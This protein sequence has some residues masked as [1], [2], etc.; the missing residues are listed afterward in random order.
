MKREVRPSVSIVKCQTYEEEEVFRSLRQSVDLLG[1]IRSFVKQGDHVLLKPNLL[2]GKEP[3]KAV[4]THPS[5]VK[6]AIHLVHE[7][8]GIPFIGDSP[9]FGSAGR[10]AEKSGIKTIA[11]EA[12]CPVVEFNNP[13]PWPKGGMLFRQFEV[14]Q[15]VLDADVV[16]NLPKWK[17]HGMVLLTLAVKNLFG[18]VPGSK[19]PLWHLKAGEDRSLFAKVLVDLYDMIRPSLNILDGIVGMEGNGPSSGVPKPLGLLL[20]SND[21]LSLDQTVCDLLRLPREALVTNRVAIEQGLSRDDALVLGLTPNE[22]R[23]EGFKFPPPSAPDWNLPGILRRALKNALSARP[24]ISE[25]LCRQCDRCA[26]ICPPKALT[27]KG[28]MP[29]FDY[30]KCIRCFCCQEICPEGAVSIQPGWALRWKR[31]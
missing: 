8:G 1:G 5:V 10:A 21:A 17:T 23:I 14:D 7:A 3:R 18:C 20:A 13:V 12:G 25:D 28:R 16:I 30:G 24:V 19:K 6:G 4:T 27:R 31:K 26:E 2:F 22:A 9:G 11:E 15:K 29:D